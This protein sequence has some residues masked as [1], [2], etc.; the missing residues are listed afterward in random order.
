MKDLEGKDQQ[1][2]I[3]VNVIPSGIPLLVGKGFLEM[4]GAVISFP[5]KKIS[6]Q[7]DGKAF[8]M[9][10]TSSGN[11]GMALSSMAE[12]S[13]VTTINYIVETFINEAIQE[14]SE[15]REMLT[16]EELLK[17]HK[18][19]NHKNANDLIFA[20]EQSGIKIPHGGKQVVKE[21]VDSC[22]T[23]VKFRKSLA[24]PTA[25]LPKAID[26]NQIVAIDLKERKDKHG[27]CI[28]YCGWWM[29]S[30]GS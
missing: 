19:N 29:S 13:N 22:V 16:H 9:T 12:L 2:E 4:T 8:D 20:I 26:F 7:Q 23:C 11:V 27:K 30:R 21:L 6:F 25:T 5:E 14:E 28:I 24:K 10:E 1:Y 3:P 18:V 15:E 17:L